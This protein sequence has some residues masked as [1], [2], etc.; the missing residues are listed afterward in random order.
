MMNLINK[1]TMCSIFHS[2][3]IS[4]V[5]LNLKYSL[6]NL[7]LPFYTQ[8]RSKT[9]LR[10]RRTPFLLSPF[11]IH[12][13]LHPFLRIKVEHFGK[14]TL[15]MIL[16]SWEAHSTTS[17]PTRSS[18]NNS[19]KKQT[20]FHLWQQQKRQLL[21]KQ[22]KPRINITQNTSTFKPLWLPQLTTIFVW[23]THNWW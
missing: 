3:F 9:I 19:N 22:T 23:K 13:E 1:Y 10:V 15:K 2:L 21:P 16:P 18:K 8:F 4:N 17:N 5:S 7:F 20:P 6:Q 14:C 11:L 12:K